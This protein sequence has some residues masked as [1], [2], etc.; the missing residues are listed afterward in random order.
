MEAEKVK[1][2]PLYCLPLIAYCLRI[3]WRRR[4]G[5]EPT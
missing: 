5:I 4:V 3:L 1:T 2:C